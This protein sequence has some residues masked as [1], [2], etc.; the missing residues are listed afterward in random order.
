M[1]KK[2]KKFHEKTM[3][4]YQK[5]IQDHLEPWKK[6][7]MEIHENVQFLFYM[8]ELEYCQKKGQCIMRGSV[9]KGTRGI[10]DPL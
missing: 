1:L 10:G 9:V 8:D 5:D 7:V 4:A 3:E 6:K 2:I